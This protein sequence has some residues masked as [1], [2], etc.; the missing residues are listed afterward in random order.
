MDVKD[1]KNVLY[2][3]L[4]YETNIENSTCFLF[5][6]DTNKFK[7]GTYVTT[8]LFSFY[9]EADE[10]SVYKISNAH[11]ATDNKCNVEIYSLRQTS[12]NA[13][14]AKLVNKDGTP[15]T[16]KFGTTNT[17]KEIFYGIIKSVLTAEV[18][19]IDENA[20]LLATID[21]NSESILGSEETA[22][23]ST[24][25][26]DVLGNTEVTNNAMIR[27]NLTVT[28]DATVGN[29]ASIKNDFT[30]GNLE[31]KKDSIVNND[32]IVKSNLTAGNLGV[33]NQLNATGKEAA[34][35]IEG[36]STAGKLNVTNELSTKDLNIV[37]EAVATGKESTFTIEDN[38]NVKKLKVTNNLT[39]KD[40]EVAN[41]IKSTGTQV[42]DDDD[43]TR[44]IVFEVTDN[45]NI[46]ELNVS[47]SA[48][49]KDLEVANKLAATGDDS[50]F[51]IKTNSVVESLNVTNNAI[52]NDLHV[53]NLIDATGEKSKFTVEQ[54]ST[55]G[56]LTAGNLDAACAD[57]SNL[58]V[59]GTLN[60]TEDV[61]VGNRTNVFNDSEIFIKDESSNISFDDTPYLNF[62]YLNKF[63]W[64]NTGITNDIWEIKIKENRYIAEK[65][66]NTIQL[67][68]KINDIT[69]D[70]AETYFSKIDATEYSGY[71]LI[72]F[73]KKISDGSTVIDSFYDAKNQQKL[74]YDSTASETSLD[75]IKRTLDYTNNVKKLSANI[76]EAKTI[77]FSD[78]LTVDGSTKI[79]D[80]NSVEG[81]IYFGNSETAVTGVM[82]ESFTSVSVI[83][84]QYLPDF[85]SMY[86]GAKIDE[87]VVSSYDDLL[88]RTI[89]FA[90][91]SLNKRGESVSEREESKIL[92]ALTSTDVTAIGTDKD[93]EDYNVLYYKDENNQKYEYSVTDGKMT[94]DYVDQIKNY[95]SLNNFN[96]SRDYYDDL[97]YDSLINDF[98]RLCPVT[99]SDNGLEYF[100]IAAK[101]NKFN[102]VTLTS[103]SSWNIIANISLLI[104][105][106]NEK[107]YIQKNYKD[108]NN[109]IRHVLL[110]ILILIAGI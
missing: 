31:V 5:A 14:Y 78:L 106:Y 68:T 35:T 19:E 45:S 66:T 90:N 8:D 83:G 4:E 34:F 9:F 49:T 52:T 84:D 11:A 86:Q 43:E 65:K 63:I 15:S 38:S 74:Q 29:N 39:T 103:S 28:N 76:L 62:K 79:G 57:I 55:V 20:T 41:K 101:I 7:I 42:T 13:F 92:F 102:Q 64:K 107:I 17:R 69:I 2:K 105:Y 58:K 98:Y 87:P 77:K 81:G 96:A 61:T 24:I 100:D 110:T 3:T 22:N 85:S 91:G 75:V 6:A 94:S 40:L 48:S 82:T 109:K 36:D 108:E 32:L 99:S 21:F 70:S 56:N 80:V 44:D 25:N 59:D 54:D 93:T 16:Q 18:S 33:T 47:G 27:G 95:A 12:G 104:V 88:N 60:T 97:T 23:A 30:S 72:C 73:T 51:T 67:G 10:N 37:N 71:S 26:V 46:N 53:T 1:F 89:N 50:V